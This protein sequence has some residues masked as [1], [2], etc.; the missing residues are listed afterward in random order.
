VIFNSSFDESNSQTY[1][2]HIEHLDWNWPPA[3]PRGK[4]ASRAGHIE[5]S[6]SKTGSDILEEAR[7]EDVINLKAERHSDEDE[8]GS[9]EVSEGPIPLGTSD[10]VYDADVDQ[11]GQGEH[12]NDRDELDDQLVGADEIRVPDDSRFPLLA[13]SRLS[14]DERAAMESFFDLLNSKEVSPAAGEH[15]ESI[16]ASINGVVTDLIGGDITSPQTINEAGW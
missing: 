12:S 1:A 2:Q 6:L 10:L 5:S 15:A 8:D 9:D 4:L 3:F 16:L 13:E 11:G 14:A 7:N